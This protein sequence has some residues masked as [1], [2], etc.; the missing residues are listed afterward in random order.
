MDFL[1]IGPSELFF[2]LLIIIVVVGPR[3]LS[4][5]GRAMGRGLHQL[6]KSDVWQTI[7]QASRELRSLPERLVREAAVEE[8]QQVVTE[9][10]QDIKASTADKSSTSKN[11]A[12]DAWTQPPSEPPTRPSEPEPK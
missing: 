11:P 5:T 7:T 9:I 6:R 1:G 4:K 12:L 8:L 2:I 10:N 3:D